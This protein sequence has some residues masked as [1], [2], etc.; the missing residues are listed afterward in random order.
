MKETDQYEKVCRVHF[1]RICNKLDEI[2][3]RLFVDNG[4]KSYQSRLGRVETF[5][6]VHLW[7]YGI[8]VVAVV[9]AIVRWAI[10]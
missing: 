5:V 4:R 3:N 6:K 8:M 10:K 2:H 1:E 9:G 7:F